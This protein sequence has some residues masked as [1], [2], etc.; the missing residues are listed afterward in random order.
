MKKIFII[1]YFCTM[2]YS[3]TFHEIKRP[4]FRQV[5][6]YPLQLALTKIKDIS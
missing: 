6:N 4:H 5:K 1:K 3:R 2:V